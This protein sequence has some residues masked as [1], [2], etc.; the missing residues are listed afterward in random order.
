[1]GLTIALLFS[2]ETCIVQMQ[3]VWVN[4]A[5]TK[6][7]SISW[8][9][10]LSMSAMWVCLPGAQY[11]LWRTN[12]LLFLVSWSRSLHFW[13]ETKVNSRCCWRC[14]LSWQVLSQQR[15]MRIYWWLCN[16]SEIQ[17]W[18]WKVWSL[19][20][21]SQSSFHVTRARKD[22]KNRQNTFFLC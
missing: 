12:K 21:C 20:V 5:C 17:L 13:R 18:L 11:P 10:R 2:L 15:E 4:F 3:T 14:V 9:K 7:F 1:M 8:Q 6:N 19:V 16:N 22:D